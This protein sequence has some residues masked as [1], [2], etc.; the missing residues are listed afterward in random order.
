M[1]GFGRAAFGFFSFGVLTM[2]CED[3]ISSRKN[4]FQVLPPI[5]P[6]WQKAC[7]IG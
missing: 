5:Q 7:R 3:V 4:L 1:R 2:K 6:W